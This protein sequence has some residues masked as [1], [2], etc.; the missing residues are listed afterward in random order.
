MK[1][2]STNQRKLHGRLLALS[3]ACPVDGSNPADCPFHECR[4]MSLLQRF[5]WARSLSQEEALEIIAIHANRVE[6]KI[7]EKPSQQKR[8]PK[9]FPRIS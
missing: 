4:K 9:D 5:E 7:K 2:I 6:K 8:N 3:E 1:P